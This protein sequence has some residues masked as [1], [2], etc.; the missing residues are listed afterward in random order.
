MEVCNNANDPAPEWEDAT[1]AAT[2]KHAH[3]FTNTMKQAPEWG[4]NVRVT[5]ERNSA[6]GDCYITGIGGN[7]E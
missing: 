1:E 6:I 5:I 4:V 7:F 3:I 2:A